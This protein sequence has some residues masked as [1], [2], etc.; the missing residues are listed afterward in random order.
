MKRTMSLVLVLAMLAMVF[1]FASAD[2]LQMSDVPGMTA[3]GVL[4]IVTEPT[5]LKIG[6]P[7]NVLV[8]DYDDNYMT[9]YA[10]ELTGIDI[11][12]DLYPGA[13][14]ATYIDLMFASGNDL[15]D[16][17]AYGTNMSFA[18]TYGA[19]GYLAPL[20][21]YFD[22]ENG[23]A[24]NFYNND[25]LSEKNIADYLTFSTSP[26]G[27]IYVFSSFVDS[28]GDTP[29]LT[30]FINRLW[31]DKL[32]LE[33]PTTLD[34]LYD[35]LVAFRDNDMDGDGD[36]TNEIPMLSSLGAWN[37]N[38]EE[39]IIN[40]FTYYNEDEFMAVK[41]GTVYAPFVTEEWQKAMIYMNKM[42][43]ENLLPAIN[44]TI[45]REELATITDS[46][47]PEHAQVGVLYG[48]MVHS[49][50]NYSSALAYD[51]M[52][53]LTGP[54]GASYAP[55]RA[56]RLN[57]IA[58]I[59]TDCEKPEIAFRFL[60]FWTEK[61][62][63]AVTFYGP[64]GENWLCRD[65]DPAAFDAKYPNANQ[66]YTSLGIAPYMVYN[67]DEGGHNIWSEENNFIWH[68]HFCCM[69]TFGNMAS[70]ATSGDF[71]ESWDEAWEKQ[72]LTGLKAYL[73]AQNVAIN[74]TTKEHQ[75]ADVY[76]NPVYSADELDQY[77]SSMTDIKTTVKE[78][79]A[80]FA[81]GAKDPVNDWDEYV[82]ALNS[83]G[84]E[85]YVALAQ[86]VYDR[87]H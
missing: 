53:I 83:I 78:Y 29:K 5:T 37:G 48:A 7:Q 33:K 4:P 36:P 51:Y 24:Y 38:I 35:V 76:A 32:G 1:A 75:P 28:A 9:K 42:V 17:L 26:D 2:E 64:V 50:P 34:E 66:T 52:P 86:N 31:L 43:S 44:F 85:D 80:N 61:K 55:I 73:S 60:D 67:T 58:F 68:M 71:I 82:N 20:T 45:T 39:L 12:F 30:G 57:P 72:D 62:N 65:D 81:T 15:P 49:M 79:I 69:L 41:D 25:T 54:E 46:V 8:T 13:E 14:T 3:P 10:E 77:N 56:M 11:E 74:L 27:E 84:L 18:T 23:L 19:Q 87:T 16:I 40:Q 21:K 59:T 70:G 47:D 63:S 6:T 22:A